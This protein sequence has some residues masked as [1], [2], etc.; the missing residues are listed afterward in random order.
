MAR[1]AAN[2]P[3]SHIWM[4]HQR[5]DAYWQQGSICQDFSAVRVPVY[6]VSGW[7][8]NYSEAIPRLLAGLSGPRLGL[9]GPWAHSFPHDVT[10]GP[11][12]GWLQEVLRW[13]DH[14]CKG[15]ATGI[16]EEPTL[17]VWM[18]DPVPPRTCYTERPGRR[19]GETV[20]PSPHI[21]PH[22]LYPGPV[23]GQQ[24]FEGEATICSPL[25][26]GLGAGEIGRYGDD[27]DWACDQRE[28]DA[29][30]LVFQSQP[31]EET[32]EILG[33]PRLQLRFKS[34]QPQA[35]IAVR[36]CEVAPDGASTRIS[37]GLL[38]LT[39]RISPEQPVALTPGL[40]TTAEVEL[41]DI[42]HSFAPGSR[43][44]LSL[45]TT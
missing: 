7:A 30:S 22:V 38:N 13:L 23:L 40:W 19:V 16:M 24:P 12:I 34:D 36:L 14:W 29:G 39:H 21:A 32:F 45:S 35:L 1:I 37:L 9:I 2:E 10:L 31:L 25:W 41:D 5:R 15:Q 11:A 18:Q 6:A 28:D 26:V 3:W 8:D 27:A 4:A 42:A 43:I 33:A 44:G 20:W 17:R